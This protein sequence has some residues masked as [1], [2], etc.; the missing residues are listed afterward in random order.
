MYSSNFY[1]VFTKKVLRLLSGTK[2]VIL[3]SWDAVFKIPWKWPFYSQNG[4]LNGHYGL[5]YYFF[6]HTTAILHAWEVFSLSG[7]TYATKLVNYKLIHW[8]YSLKMAV[9]WP[10]M[11]PK[12]ASNGNISSFFFMDSEKLFKIHYCIKFPSIWINIG[13]VLAYF[14]YMNNNKIGSMLSF[15]HF[16]WLTI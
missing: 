10:K 6:F 7:C 11:A 8:P 13:Q 16:S 4:L 9:F 15:L 14:V 5:K 2:N 12:M 3:N 1:P